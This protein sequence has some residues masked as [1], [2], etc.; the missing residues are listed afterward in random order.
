MLNFKSKN[1][2]GLLALVV[3]SVWFF[4][5]VKADLLSDYSSSIPV[6]CDPLAMTAVYLTPSTIPTTLSGNTIYVLESWDYQ[7]F[8]PINL[9]SC[10]SLVGS[11]IVTLLGMNSG[12]NVLYIHNNSATTTNIIIKN[13]TLDGQNKAFQWIK[14]WDINNIILDTVDV[15]GFTD[16]GIYLSKVSLSSI[17]NVNIHN[18]STSSTWLFLSES[19]SNTLINNNVY[20]NGY[21]I[22]IQDW[23][24]NTITNTN[25]YNNIWYGIGISSSSNN[26]INSWYISWNDYGIRV[27]NDSQNTIIDNVKVNNNTY[28]ILAN[29]NAYNTQIRNNTEIFSNTSDGIFFS[30]VTLNTISNTYIHNNGWVGLSFQW[31]SNSTISSNQISGNVIGISLQW[32]SSNNTIS[33][34]TLRNNT[35]KWV[36]LVNSTGNT[37]SSST[38]VGWVDG[39]YLDWSNSNTLTDNVQSKSIKTWNW[40]YMNNSSNNTIGG[41]YFS[42]NEN[43]ICLNW[44]SNNV[45]NATQTIGNSYGMLLGYSSNANT[46]NLLNNTNWIFLNYN[47][48][49]NKIN[50]TQVIWEN[51]IFIFNGSNNIITWWVV[52]SATTAT[53]WIVISLKS[54]LADKSYAVSGAWVSGIF[55]GTVVWNSMTGN[56]TLTAWYWAKPIIVSYA[57]GNT[58]YDSINYPDPTPP[59]WGWGWWG[60]GW[61]WWG[62]IASCVLSQLVCVDGK[63]KVMTGKNCSLWIYASKSCT[64]P[65][66]T[67]NNWPIGNIAGSTYSKEINDAYLRAYRFGITTMPTIQRANMKWELSRKHLAK[68]ISNFAINVVG[69]KIDTWMICNFTDMTKESA[70]MKLYAK[71]SCQLGIMGL[72]ADGTPNTKF[73]PNGIVSRSQFGTV[74]S[75]LIWWDKYNGGE[76][77]YTNHLLA[78]QRNNIMT[79]IDNPSSRTELRRWVMVMLKRT[80]EKWFFN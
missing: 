76:K 50:N 37:I 35:S 49:S 73:N 80:F 45:F 44:S 59:S 9:T 12:V 61:G 31:V 7:I 60:W 68:M 51:N 70:E 75:R 38:I 33:S 42:W 43:G 79:K 24:N 56:I 55:S 18:N 66:W 3:L 8:S 15:K 4:S 5:I 74:L 65:S 13:I 64:V 78:L 25:V 32:Y 54:D 14:A 36:Y 58:Y 40:L 23:G 26:T 67:T 10:V 52:S 39:I 16:K 28:G 69:L 62:W 57:N 41:W 34:N 53:T 2:F 77:Y 63:Y 46:I 17:S 71:I 21:G 27:Q 29:G 19:N 20:G 48:D 6:G 22:V 47:S 1:M 11:G 72:K 30:N